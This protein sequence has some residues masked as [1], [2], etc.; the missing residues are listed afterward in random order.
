MLI[1]DSW[2]MTGYYQCSY[3]QEFPINYSRIIENPLFILGENAN[4]G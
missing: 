1:T 2:T 3:E 4:Y